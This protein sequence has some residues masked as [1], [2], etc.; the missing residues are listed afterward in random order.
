MAFK[1]ILLRR[2]TAA[3]WTSGNPTLASGEIGYESNTGKFKI[4][5]GSTAWTSLSYSNANLPGASINDLGDVTITAAADGDFLRWNGTVWI[6]DAVNLSTDTVGS[7]VQSL[8]AGTGVTITNNTGEGATPT[9]AVDTAAIQARVTGVS[10]IEIGYLDGVTSA[11]QTQID[12]KAPLASPT[13]TTPDIGVATGT[14]LSLSGAAT[15]SSHAVTKSYVDA[16]AAGINWHDAVVYA[17]ATALPNTPIY[18]NGASGVGATLTG[19]TT[20][21]LLIDGLNATTGNRILVKNQALAIHNGIYTVT[22]QGSVSVAWVITR[23]TDF[24][25]DTV[26]GA[27]NT[28]EAVYVTTGSTNESTGFV[29]TSVGTGTSERHI[30]GTDDFTFTQ[31]SGTST[32]LA[33][34]GLVKNGLVLDVATASSARIVINAD[35]IDLASISQSNSTGTT[36]TSFAQS[37]SVDSYGRVTGVVTAA[38]DMSLKANLASPT[39]SGTVTL[40]NGQALVAPVLGTPVS[41]VM[42]NVT[43]IVNTG[44]DASAAIALSK[45]ATGALPTAITV[46]SA[47]IVDDSIVNADIN[48]AADIVDTKLATISTALKVSNSATTATSVNTVSAI[49]A[50]DASGNFVAGTITAALTGTASGNLVSGGA[51]GTPSSG[52]AD[53]MT[54]NT[55]AAGDS[56]TQLATTAFVTTADDLKANLADP[57][58]T[59]TVSGVTKTMV[60]LGN[61]DNT[62]DAG[63]PVSTAGQTALDL[64]SNLAGPTFTGVPAAPTATAGTNTTQLSTTE[65]VTAAVAAGVVTASA[66]AILEAL[67]DAKGDLIVG[68]ANDTPARLAV[69]INGYFLK[70]NSAATTGVEWGEV[71]L[72]TKANLASPTFTGTVTVPTP[73]NATDAVTKSYADAIKQGLDI[74]DSVRVASTADIAIAT[75]LINA[76]VIDG[77]TV[78]TGDRVLLKNQTAGAENGIYVVVASG[79]ASRSTDASTSTDVTSGMYTFV[80]EGTVSASMGFVLTTADP[81]TLAT[82]ALTLTQFSGAGQITAGAGLTK[83]GNTLA[84]N[85]DVATLTGSQT[86]TN[87]TLT[88]PTVNS[89]TGIVKGDVGLGSVD[90]TTDAAKPVS[91]AGQTALDLKSNIASPTFTGVPA[92]PTAAVATNTTQLAT[93]AFVLANAPAAVGSADAATPFNTTIGFETLNALTTGTNNVAV[94]YQALYSNTTGQTN[95]ATGYYALFSNTTGSYNVAVGQVTLVNNTTGGRNTATGSHALLSNSTGSFNTATG[96]GALRNNTTGDS[97]VAAGYYALYNSTTG[98]KNVATGD[99]ALYANTTGGNNVA[100]G[101][102][103]L[104]ANTT[105]T[106]NTATGRDALR[107]NTTGIN[108]VAIGFDA[109]KTNVT[110]SGSVFIGYSAGSAETD[111][112][113]LYIANSSTSTPLIGGDFSAA[114]VTVTGTLTVTGNIKFRATINTQAVTALTLALSNLAETIM[115]NHANPMTVTVPSNATAAFAIGDKVEIVRQGAGALTIA[116]AAGV[117]VNA[118]PGLKL[119]AQWSSGTLV[120]TGTDI[121]LLIGDLAA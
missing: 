13:L 82:T 60:G 21:R 117:T 24:D 32:T 55:E 89:P 26:V 73:T 1:R 106:S 20:V 11:V 35:S 34:S 6:N 53:N 18:S 31:F 62:S 4:G 14:S 78:A 111:S 116:A 10:D 64:K 110:G 51:L 17:T 49:V 46:A 40:P 16:L 114:T 44:I 50:R 83:T 81:I 27:L 70:A 91:T 30:P 118:T 79:V 52:V 120:K 63:K 37:V 25:Q 75:A 84:I 102:S 112:N 87:K 56:T 97:N 23:A 119:R 71:D 105:G 65:F 33:G 47:N 80:S 61:V 88:S 5:N 12:T 42:T 76:S 38:V 90:N 36:G 3:L 43:G 104:Y 98:N 96:V 54:S 69:G 67:I 101:A 41:G 107:N 86:L 100:A 7:Y 8:V 19:D 99:S 58:F 39:F 121:W 22:A 95:T 77:V 92:A 15:S 103:A 59:G 66:D 108:N 29:L 93:T 2:D 94:G 109:G 57:T 74:K 48:S 68:T 85:T 45:L 115:M 113:K 9:V 72:T 28:G